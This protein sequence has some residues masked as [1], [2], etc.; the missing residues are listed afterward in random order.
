M[1]IGDIFIEGGFPGHAML[2]VDM[3]ENIESGKRVFL[4]AQSYM[5]AQNIHIVKN[6]V[7]WGLSP[8]YKADFGDRLYTLEWVFDKDDLMRFML[9]FD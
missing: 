2:V 1:K 6:Q 8:W 4:L 5:P 7:K 9:G 3:A